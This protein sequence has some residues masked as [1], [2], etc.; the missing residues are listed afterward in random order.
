MPKYYK[1]PRSRV[2]AL[3]DEATTW[4]ANGPVTVWIHGKGK[5]PGTLAV[6]SKSGEEVWDAPESMV[7]RRFSKA[8]QDPYKDFVVKDQMVGTARVRTESLSLKRIAA[9][10]LREA[11]EEEKE[12]G[13]DSLDAQI[14]KYLSSY[15]TEAKNAKTEGLDIRMMTRRFLSEAEDEEEDKGDEGEADKEDDATEEEPEKLKAEDLD[16]GSFV[17]SVVRLVDNYDTLLE[18]RN[19]I[20]RRAVNHLSKNYEGD[21]ADAFKEELLEAYGMEIGVTQSEKEDELEFQPPKA[22]AAGPAGGGGA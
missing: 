3:P 7:K 11:D 12:E 14:D 6:G 17:A 10:L 16:M 9:T 15:E 8:D 19:T 20:L 18:V 4:D 5:A 2:K 21:A 1:L 13:E 22:G